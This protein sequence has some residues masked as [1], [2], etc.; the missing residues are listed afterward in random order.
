MMPAQTSTVSRKLDALIGEVRR[1][2]RDLRRVLVIPTETL[3]D[4]QNPVHIVRAYKASFG[5]RGRSRS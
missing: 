3:E 2:R 5:S 1:L 4:Y